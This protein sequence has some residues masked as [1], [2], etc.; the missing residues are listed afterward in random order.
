MMLAILNAYLSDICF[1]VDCDTHKRTFRENLKCRGK[2]HF[3][4]RSCGTSNGL[5]DALRNA[6]KQCLKPV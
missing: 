6:S 3:K 4:K 1:V 5:L 2:N